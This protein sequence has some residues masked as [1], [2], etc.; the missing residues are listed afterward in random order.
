MLTAARALL[1]GLVSNLHLEKCWSPFL[2]LPDFDIFQFPSGQNGLFSVPPK[3]FPHTASSI[4]NLLRSLPSEFVAVIGH[5]IESPSLTTPPEVLPIAH[6]NTEPPPHEAIW[7]RSGRRWYRQWDSLRCGMLSASIYAV[8]SA[9]ST[10][11]ECSNV[12]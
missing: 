5:F 4:L 1:D 8:C 7:L 10:W 12:C 2:Y 11:Q 6:Q 3:V 9:S